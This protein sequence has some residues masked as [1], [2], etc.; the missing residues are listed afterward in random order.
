MLNI[1]SL[2]SVMFTPDVVVADERVMF[3]DD[4]LSRPE[5]KRRELSL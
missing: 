3:R 2:T 4:P 1:G 5:S